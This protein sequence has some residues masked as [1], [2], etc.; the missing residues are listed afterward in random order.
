MKRTDKY[1]SI[2]IA[3]AGIIQAVTLVKDIAQSGKVDPFYF[4]TSLY[5]IFPNQSGKYCGV[6]RGLNGIKLGLEKLIQLLGA[7]VT[8]QQTKYLLMI[9]H[10]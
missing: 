3:L 5:S 9:T 10:L 4:E 1:E 8:P 2:T 7:N 6:F